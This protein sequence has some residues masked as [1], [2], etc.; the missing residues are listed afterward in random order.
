MSTCRPITDSA[1]RITGAVEICKDMQEI[2]ELAQSI[3]RAFDLYLRGLHRKE[4]GRPGS[5]SVRQEDCI[6]G[7]D[8]FHPGRER[9]GQGTLRPTPFTPQATETGLS[10][11]STVPPCRR[12]YWRA[13]SSAT[14]RGLSRGLREAAN[15]DCSNLRGDGTLFL[16]EI[17]EMPLGVQAK[18]LRVIQEKCL[19][20]IGGIRE[21]PIHCR[22]ITATNK[23][24]ELLVRE[25]AFREDLY[26]RGTTYFR[27]TSRL[28][29]SGRRIFLPSP[30]TSFSNSAPSSKKDVCPF[31]GRPLK[32]CA[33]TSG[34]E[35]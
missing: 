24:L 20:P 5:H 25:N 16:D 34:A 27:S 19:R 15:R 8:G 28:C 14:H 3:F 26:Y 18:I 4:S 21:I 17:G 23:S 30:N 22:I 9:Y 7:F 12:L 33:D 29:G 1:N 32:N 11:P 10:S 6:H 13:N 2:K 35:T 31:R